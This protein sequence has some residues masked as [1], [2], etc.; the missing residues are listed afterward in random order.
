MRSGPLL[1]TVIFTAIHGIVADEIS[2]QMTRA[3]PF[4]V[5]LL[6]M[7]LAG[8]YDPKQPLS[9][10]TLLMA[11]LRVVASENARRIPDFTCGM[12][13]ERSLRRAR[14]GRFEPADTLRLEVAFAGGK[15]M[16]AWPGA[17]SFEQTD[18]T[19]LVG[20]GGAIGSGDFTS[21]VQSV[22]LSD[23]PQH[24]YVGEEEMNGHQTHRFD[25]TVARARSRYVLRIPPIEEA[26]GYRGSYWVDT[27]SM[28]IVRLVVD[29]DDIPPTLPVRYS[30]KVIDLE[31]QMIGETQFLLP[32]S[33]EMEMHMK[34][35]LASLNRTRFLNCHQFRG[36]SSLSFEDPPPEGEVKAVTVTMTLPAGLALNLELA[37]PLDLKT[38]A[39]GDQV[40]F[41][42]ARDAKNKSGVVA[43]KGAEF[44]G[45]VDMVACVDSAVAM[46]YVLLH[47]ENF[48]WANKA[49]VVRAGLE[50][51]YFDPLSVPGAVR[52]N[53]LL[54]IPEEVIRHPKDQGVVAIRGGRQTIKPGYGLLWRVLPQN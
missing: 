14:S 34:D 52:R 23:S 21:H 24:T 40:F 16:Y 2:R 45:R 41:T 8:Q 38:A 49:G 9:K 12:T 1:K 44:S 43:P 30:R 46:C 25:Y 29:V 19:A 11:R 4:V 27:R 3:R 42:L 32:V 53:G 20:T 48:Q 6:P 28:D 10:Q 31:R 17:K 36:E 50:A 5:A 54:L 47:L 33:S 13:V 39:R 22:L 37:K 7:L 26:V 51:P 15:E 35:G 18:I